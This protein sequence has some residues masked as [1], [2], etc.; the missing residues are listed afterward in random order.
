M[1]CPSNQLRSTNT[2]VISCLNQL[3]TSIVVLA[4]LIVI[5]A[6]VM[7]IGTAVRMRHPIDM[8]EAATVAVAARVAAGEPMYAEMHKP[9]GIEPGLYSPLQ[10]LTL[11]AVFKATGPSL[12]PGRVINV[13]AGMAFIPLFLRALGI[14]RNGWSILFGIAF[15]LALDE[16]L[17]GLWALPRA[18]A[19]PLL[20]AIVFVSA[21]YR[22]CSENS[23]RW[24]ALAHV[25]LLIGFFWKQTILAVAPAPF[26]AAAISRTAPKRMMATFLVGPLVCVVVA[27][28]LIR[29][30]SPN[31]YEAMF[32][33]PAGF[34]IRPRMAALFAYATLLAAPLQWLTIGWIASSDGLPVRDKTK[35]TWAVASAASAIPL[36]FLALAKVGGGP[37]SL[38][39]VVYGS[40][41]AVLCCVPSFHQFLSSPTAGLAKR[42][43]LGVS[44]AITLGLTWMTILDTPRRVQLHRSYGD[45]GRPKVIAIA[46]SLPGKVVSPQDPTIALEAKGYAGIGSVNEW[47]RRLWKWPLSKT[48]QEMKGADYVV[49][50]GLTNTW[51]TW[52]FDEGFQALTELG[53]EAMPV[54]GLQNSHYKI[55]KRNPPL[56]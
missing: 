40:G 12:L 14:C 19:V 30:F 34:A 55:W 48:I 39:Y 44:L 18:D 10:S 13:L 54:E 5:L 11:A 4:S 41:A 36:N 28:G 46:K 56:N 24:A 26:L 25:A 31:M 51:E 3:P 20:C 8:W 29:G 22:A 33:T 42:H 2:A 32:E 50:W 7:K 37:N 38:A 16:Q 47:D 1:P 27:V 17:T 9:S 53:F 23:F 21:A 6:S 49:T 43:L 35:F 52:T 15:L 45:A